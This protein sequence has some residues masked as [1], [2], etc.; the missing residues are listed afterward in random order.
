M[1]YL[2]YFYVIILITLFV[3]PVTL[4]A[5]QGNYAVAGLVKDEGGKAVGYATLGILK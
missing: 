1:L 2:R 3:L 5:Q 4:T